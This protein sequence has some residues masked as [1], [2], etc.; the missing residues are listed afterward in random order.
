[1]TDKANLTQNILKA[2]YLEETRDQADGAVDSLTD[3]ILTVE[4]A[5]GDYISLIDRAGDYLDLFVFFNELDHMLSRLKFIFADFE[6]AHFSWRKLL[7]IPQ[8]E[9][10]DKEFLEE[11]E[12]L[13]DYIESPEET[14]EDW[15]PEDHLE[16]EDPKWLET[17]EGVLNNFKRI[18]IKRGEQDSF[19]YFFDPFYDDSYLMSTVSGNI[20]EIYADL[21]EI[22]GFVEKINEE[23]DPEAYDDLQDL[24]EFHCTHHILLLLWAV[25]FLIGKGL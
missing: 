23:W 8:E 3:C 15:M 7:D 19:W 11:L 20:A 22:R 25:Q 10:E 1:M 4:Q 21:V 12:E 17:M 9:I 13:R 5:A 16:G 2:E 18:L 6:R 14:V 24:L